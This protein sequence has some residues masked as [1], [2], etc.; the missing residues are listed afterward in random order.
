MGL[1][2]WTDE[3]EKQSQSEAKNHQIP[4]MAEANDP[5][6]LPLSPTAE[7]ALARRDEEGERESHLSSSQNPSQ[8]NDE[9]LS[10]R[11]ILSPR[12]DLLP[13]PTPERRSNNGAQTH[14]ESMGGGGIEVQSRWLPEVG[15]PNLH[16]VTLHHGPRTHFPR[17]RR[18]SQRSAERQNTAGRPSHSASRFVNGAGVEE[19]RRLYYYSS[20]ARPTR[21]VRPSTGE[22][23]SVRSSRESTNR[24]NHRRGSRLRAQG[25]YMTAIGE[26]LPQIGD[27]GVEPFLE[28]MERAN[29]AIQAVIARERAYEDMRRP[30]EIPTTDHEVP[31]SVRDSL[32][33]QNQSLPVREENGNGNG[34]ESNQEQAPNNQDRQIINENFNMS[35][36][37]IEDVVEEANS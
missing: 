2:L 22:R 9:P 7:E 13:P 3:D 35:T 28:V 30:N 4:L 14:G 20:H 21:I 36:Q 26:A 31:I 34:N 33:R 11:S 37:T 1:R 29:V 6:G 17:N 10:P 12:Q 23:I 25:R 5:N 18:L 19:P 8:P 32:S 27:R 15:S 16:S 24:E